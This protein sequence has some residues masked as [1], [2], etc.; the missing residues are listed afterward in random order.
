MKYVYL[1]NSNANALQNDIN[2]LASKSYKIV[3]HQV[4]G[5]GAASRVHAV[6]MEL[7]P[8][9]NILRKRNPPIGPRRY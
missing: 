2:K 1:F 3:S 4:A 6:I 8:K 9:P 7:T 5:A